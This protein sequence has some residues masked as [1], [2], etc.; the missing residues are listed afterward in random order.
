MTDTERIEN[1]A[2][3]EEK[4]ILTDA[5]SIPADSGAP[6]DVA[7]AAPSEE[8][9]GEGVKAAS[10]GGTD[11]YKGAM[12]D[13]DS[14]TDYEALAKSDLEELWSLF[15]AL[16]SMRSITGLHDPL[17]YAA[18]RDLGLTPK[19]AYL[20]TCEPSASYDNRSHLESTEYGRRSADE[21]RMSRSEM[22]AARELF[23]GLSD[24]E[25]TRLYK[26]VNG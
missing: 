22:I 15:P 16:R 26:R 10:E 23:S 3:T 8:N 12:S 4:S 1:E 20:A 24:R 21:G 11:G 14:A 7:A 25:I 6:L 9:N 5:A 17:R 2:A 13:S 18:L 19:E